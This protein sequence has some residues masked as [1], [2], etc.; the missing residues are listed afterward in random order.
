LAEIKSVSVLHFYLNFHRSTTDIIDQ[1]VAQVKWDTRMSASY[2]KLLNMLKQS[3]N[4]AADQSLGYALLS[5]DTGRI[6][7]L[8][9]S[10]LSRGNDDAISYVIQVF[11][12]LEPVLKQKVISRC[13]G[14]SGA[15][16]R[17]CRHPDPVVRQNIIEIIDAGNHPKLSYVLALMV[18][19]DLPALRK[20]S[21]EVFKKGGIALLSRLYEEIGDKD[22]VTGN[23]STIS[24]ADDLN[25]FFTALEM[26][27]DN[28]SN[29]R[30]FEVIEVAMMFSPWLN[31]K[32]WSRFTG[33]KS[34]IGRVAAELL[35][36]ESNPKY[37]GF[38]FRALTSPEL[39]KQIAPLIASKYNSDF[40]R[41][42]LKYAQ[43][44]FDAN[45][46]KNLARIK[47]FRW[48]TGDR[49]PLLE[50]EPKLQ[51]AFIDV[52]MLSGSS[53]QAKLDILETLMVSHDPSVQEHVVSALIDSN[54]PDIA[55]LLQRAVAFGNAIPFS[56]SASRMA[57]TYLEQLKSQTD[58]SAILPMPDE[59]P[60]PKPEEPHYFDR[61]WQTFEQ[62]DATTCFD[63]VDRLKKLDTRF[64]IH[65]NEK[66]NSTDPADRSRAIKL[67]RQGKL[68]ESYAEK[69][70]G[71]CHDGDIVVRSAAV[72]TLGGIPGKKTEEQLIEALDDENLRVQANAIESLEKLNPPELADLLD[73]KLQSQNNRVR[74][75]AIKAILKPQYL[76]ALRA[77]GAMLE[78]PD[79]AFRR[80]ALWVISQAAPLHLA[81]RVYAMTREDADAEVRL[82]AQQAIG[83]LLDCWK[84]NKGKITEVTA[85]GA[86]K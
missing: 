32:L 62:L 66:L 3:E 45:A 74:A 64:E 41:Q 9:G 71:L 68:T 27:L 43:Y 8:T 10:L 22:P 84:N 24:L 47:E 55:R 29:H 35:S 49:K 17:L 46:R 51:N 80:S 13:P 20:R 67:V 39:G 69:L 4:P 78:H 56:A 16:R 81:K 75:N 33:D 31:E 44:R 52:L 38:A 73:E 2:D 65:L 48:L 58:Q 61:F 19:D 15:L 25:H 82:A 28:F 42:W 37:A 23:V 63:A 26:I 34:R 36:R 5:A 21:A 72:S 54:L 59:T 6:F 1:V 30:R 86:E 76:F 53:A 40:I 70:Y 85:M 11:H 18:N 60:S 7:D 77:L 79:P 12:K 57:G 14:I 50:T 83:N